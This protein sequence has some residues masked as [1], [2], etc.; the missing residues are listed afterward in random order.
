MVNGSDAW[1]NVDS[2]VDMYYGGEASPNPSGG[3][4]TSPVP[5]SIA[6]STGT[7]SGNNELKFRK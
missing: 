7:T 2:N 3:G 5:A 1:Y 4:G 6:A